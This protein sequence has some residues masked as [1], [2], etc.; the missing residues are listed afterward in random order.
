MELN[1]TRLTDNIDNIIELLAESFREDPFYAVLCAD[2]QKRKTVL[3]NL[4][5]I[6]LK[7]CLEFG[8]VHTVAEKGEIIAAALWLDYRKL[9]ACSPT[10]Y[11]FIFKLTGEKTRRLGI[12]KRDYRYISSLL[13]NIKTNEFKEKSYYLLA[14][15]VDKS[16]RK[17]GIATRLIKRF[18]NM[19]TGCN[20]Y[21]DVF[22]PQALKLYY[23]C[24]Y[25]VFENKEASL[26]YYFI[27]FEPNPVQEYK[28]IR[29]LVP[30]D[31]NTAKTI[32]R[33]GLDESVFK[34]SRNLEGFCAVKY[35]SV[36]YLKESIND[37]IKLIEVEINHV[38][39]LIE[40]ERLIDVNNHDQRMHCVNGILDIF[41]VLTDEN[42]MEACNTYKINN[43]P[44]EEKKFTTDVHTIIPITYQDINMIKNSIYLDYDNNTY[45]YLDNMEFRQRFECGVSDLNMYKNVSDRGLTS[46]INDRLERFVI[47]D[48]LIIIKEELTLGRRIKDLSILCKPQT[49]NF[50]ITIDKKSNCGVVTIFALSS[51]F[52][53]T[54]YLD[55]V[56]RHQ[57]VISRNGEEMNLYEFL[58]KGF[59]ITKSGNPKSFI[60][61]ADG[62][63][64]TKGIL[65]SILFGE[66]YYPSEEGMG[67]IK[68][69]EILQIIDQGGSGQYEYAQ[70]YAY[71]NVMIQITKNFG[72]T[73]SERLKQETITAFYI[74][75]ILMHEAAVSQAN[76]HVMTLLTDNSS[77]YKSKN[78]YLNIINH[79]NIE[80]SKS[81]MFW[82]TEMNYPSSQKSVDMI[83]EAFNHKSLM[84]TYNRNIEFINFMVDIQAN[85]MENSESS[86]L[87]F[88]VLVLTV[89]Q[90]IS[91]FSAFYGISDGLS[92]V[93]LL[94]G[95]SIGLTIILPFLILYLIKRKVSRKMIKGYADMLK[96]RNK[97]N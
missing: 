29:L 21:A 46:I 79:I 69:R 26:S 30:D 75:M 12:N 41:Y 35:G 50:A 6:S 13:S 10:D 87:N 33:I 89:L 39:S 45:D 92:N 97:H 32:Q 28:T 53:I 1:Q 64:I 8:Y 56:S 76:S 91:S 43:K 88:I 17:Q 66:T 20:F 95:L 73:I 58:D 81:I 80:Y 25:S 62:Y 16:Y 55:N 82:D 78:Y 72:W 19:K 63:P 14:I 37:T 51:S 68:D 65:A 90:I 44:M 47:K 61:V 59:S 67:N 83:K 71:R 85:I 27:S 18:M 31:K 93:T 4:F 9:K 94:K 74:E 52:A 23:K 49:V 70:I 86:T 2:A 60:T 48:V 77:N 7:I 54:Q 5:G 42:L 3:K 57:I 15:C 38:M 34:E 84:D 24:Q 36:T 11:D 40:Y 96:S 22:N